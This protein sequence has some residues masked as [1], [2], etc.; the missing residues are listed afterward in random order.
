MPQYIKAYHLS[1]HANIQRFRGFYSAKHGARGIFVSDSWVSVLND[2][3]GTLMDKRFGGRKISTVEKRRRRLR[4]LEERNKD[5]DLEKVYDK[6]IRRYVNQRPGIYQNITIYELLIPMDVFKICTQRT[7]ALAEEAFSTLG[8]GAIGAWGWGVETF[9]LEEYLPQ[10]KIIGRK[11]YTKEQA[12]QLEERY[13][14]RQ[15][16]HRQNIYLKMQEYQREINYLIS[17]F[18]RAPLLDRAYRYAN[19]IE[20]IDVHRATRHYKVLDELLRP[21]RRQLK[22]D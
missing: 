21:Y 8:A 5:R 12:W 2:W 19:N 20:W 15:R 14:D 22:E 16:V 7:D 3:L 4:R 13:R 6:K 18:G 1:P 11:T 9:I 10:I 17:I